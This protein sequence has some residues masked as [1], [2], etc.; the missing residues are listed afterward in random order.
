M[1]SALSIS[2]KVLL[3]CCIMPVAC[4]IFLVIPQG[5]RRYFA[6]LALGLLPF[7]VVA[8]TSPW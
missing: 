5:K 3:N 1:S 7:F 6:A 8:T 4:S 2:Q